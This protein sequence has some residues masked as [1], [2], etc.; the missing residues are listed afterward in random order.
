M[1]LTN[2]HVFFETC[3]ENVNLAYGLPWGLFL[4]GLVSSFTHCV[5][6][7][8]PFVI[9]Q[10]GHL[11]KTRDAMLVPY[12]MGRIVTYTILAII[13]TSLVN[14]VAFFSPVRVLIVAPLLALSG[15]VFIV[16][17]IPKLRIIFPWVNRLRVI[18]GQGHIQKLFSKTNNRFLAGMALGLM[19]CGMVVGAIMAASTASSYSLTAMSMIAFGVGTM[20]ALFLTALGGQKLQQKFP[21][22][23]PAIR[24]GF[25]IWSG[26]WLFAMAGLV[27]LRG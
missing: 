4:V 13:M 26:L 25:M 1:D 6:M 10:S 21:N 12:H 9:S 20:P 15:L 16:S 3:F 18:I 14:V 27:V 8:G 5:G 22:K 2:F 23:M 7:C 24:S 17:A 19:P 11:S